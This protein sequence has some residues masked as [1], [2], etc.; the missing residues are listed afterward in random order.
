[1]ADNYYA[2]PSEYVDSFWNQLRRRALGGQSYDPNIV[3]DASRGAY[4]AAVDKMLAR[5]QVANAEAAQKATEAYQTGTL[6]LNNAANA[7]RDA[8]YKGAIAAE[9]EKLRQ[10]GEQADLAQKSSLYN[11]GTQLGGALLTG[12][13]FD[14]GEKDKLGRPIKTSLLDKGIGDWFNSTGGSNSGKTTGGI[15]GDYSDVTPEQMATWGEAPATAPTTTSQA[16][17]IGSPVSTNDVMQQA[18]KD[19][20]DTLKPTPTGGPMTA[21]ANTS[22][23]DADNDLIVSDLFRRIGDPVNQIGGKPTEQVRYDE[24]VTKT[25]G[26]EPGTGNTSGSTAGASE[27]TAEFPAFVDPTESSS[28]SAPERDPFKANIAPYTKPADLSEQAAKDYAWT[29][30]TSIKN[31]SG[32]DYALTN[33]TYQTEQKAK[34]DTWAAQQTAAQKAAYDTW[35]AAENEKAL[36]EYNTW[37]DKTLTDAKAAYE[38]DKA[39]Y[40]KEASTLGGVS[41]AK[42]SNDWSYNKGFEGARPDYYG[43]EFT[44]GADKV[45]APK[46]ETGGYADRGGMAGNK[47]YVP[48]SYGYESPAVRESGG[49]SEWQSPYN[50]SQMDWGGGGADYSSPEVEAFNYEPGS[51][52]AASYGGGSGGYLGGGGGGYYDYGGGDS[53]GGGGGKIVCTELNRRGYLPDAIL[54]S[55]SE[56]RRKTIPFDVYVGYL[57]LFS[58]VV[59]LMKQSKIF[60]NIVRPFGVATAHEMA[61]RV[62][63]SVKGTLLGK[64]VLKVG[65][66]IC[67]IV[68][69]LAMRALATATGNTMEVQHG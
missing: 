16:A 56:C 66:P 63:P 35:V 4:G 21:A 15:A 22:A 60:T 52:T 38:E 30:G 40:E 57:T 17:P 55:D 48:P 53:G 2:A 45:V 65:I 5:R 42:A 36:N 19:S 67:R 33:Q 44:H 50:Y 25:A 69:G 12:R 23:T 51:Y 20:Q 46:F 9:N 1:M 62:D 27:A 10:T 32:G 39:A 43:H 34:Y 61:S 7:S 54:Q 3:R 18:F 14:T 64:L 68:G 26:V 41:E 29:H 58:P 11:L 28:F 6:E 8:Y 59:A 31:W 37:K 47:A 49:A 13:L 24:D